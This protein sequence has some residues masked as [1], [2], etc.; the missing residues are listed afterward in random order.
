MTF[1]QVTLYRPRIKCLRISIC[2]S[3][4]LSQKVSILIN[5]LKVVQIILYLKNNLFIIITIILEKTP[6]L[7]QKHIW[8]L[9]NNWENRIL[10]NKRKKINLN[11]IILFISTKVKYRFLRVLVNDYLKFNNSNRI[12]LFIVIKRIIIFL[13]FKN[14]EI[15]MESQKIKNSMSKKIKVISQ[16]M[17][18][19]NHIKHLLYVASLHSVDQVIYYLEWITHN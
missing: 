1:D 10:N 13:L 5:I 18:N 14:V 9:I 4:S 2:F 15:P 3:Y 6:L 12:L 19:K 16:T 17:K 7:R 11:K 8:A